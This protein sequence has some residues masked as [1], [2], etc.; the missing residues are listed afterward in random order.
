L[1]LV[2]YREIAYFFGDVAAVVVGGIDG[3]CH[4]RDTSDPLWV[5]GGAKRSMNPEK[6]CRSL[7]HFI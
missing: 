6:L 1:V 3:V 2:E 4:N 7:C 5:S